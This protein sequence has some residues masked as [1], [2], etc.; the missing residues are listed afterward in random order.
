M[1]YGDSPE[2]VRLEGADLDAARSHASAAGSELSE[3]AR[4][5]SRAL[6]REDS[7]KLDD[8]GFS[9]RVV[10]E[11]TAAHEPVDVTLGIY[12]THD[13][14]CLGVFDAVA[15]VCRACTDAEAATCLQSGG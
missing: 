14:D 5:V 6:G 12:C 11:R 4:I 8:Q 9:V 7:A 10:V 15:M 2:G 13:G 1:S 3:L